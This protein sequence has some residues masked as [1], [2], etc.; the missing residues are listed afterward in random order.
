MISN[1]KKKSQQNC[2]RCDE[3]RS[4][5]QSDKKHAVCSGDYCIVLNDSVEQGQCAVCSLTVYN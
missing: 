5:V 3:K 2:C 1:I 4:E